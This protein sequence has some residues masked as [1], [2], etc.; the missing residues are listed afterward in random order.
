MFF[1]IPETP[2]KTLVRLKKNLLITLTSQKNW[3]HH[4]GHTAHETYIT[5]TVMEY[6]HFLIAVQQQNN[7]KSI[8]R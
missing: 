5:D 2:T 4:F 8:L 6:A 7:N 3:T 1:L